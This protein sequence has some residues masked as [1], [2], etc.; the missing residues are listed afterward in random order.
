MMK[1]R[2]AFYENILEGADETELQLVSRLIEE[3]VELEDRMTEL[4][5]LPF[6]AVNPKNPAMQRRTPAAAVYK[7]CLGQYMNAIRILVNVCRK[8]EP[9]AADELM[10]RLEEFA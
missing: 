6:V 7:D 8:T 3:V 10:K 1:D 2:V 9:S 5:Q 4:K